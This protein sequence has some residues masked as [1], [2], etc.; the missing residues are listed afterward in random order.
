MSGVGAFSY[1]A[2]IF[3]MIAGLYIV[4]ARENLMKKLVGLSIFRPP[5]ICSTS[6]PAS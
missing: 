4:M 5:F 1:W 2:T 3:I 6:H